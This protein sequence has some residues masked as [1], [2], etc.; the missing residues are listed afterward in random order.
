VEQ[1]NNLPQRRRPSGSIGI[2][3]IS[4]NYVKTLVKS[5]TGGI[6]GHI[7]LS[8]LID[9]DKNSSQLSKAVTTGG[10]RG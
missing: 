9:P 3:A 1:S 8:A 7:L 2:G 10:G 4:R 5:L 6:S